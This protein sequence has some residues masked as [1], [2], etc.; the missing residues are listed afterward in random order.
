MCL[1]FGLSNVAVPEWF[2]AGA[3]G[4]VT[5][6]TLLLRNVPALQENLVSVF[7]H[8]FY[9]IIIFEQLFYK[10]SE[11]ICGSVL[12]ENYSMSNRCFESA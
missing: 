3:F 2:A 12:E 4:L 7:V 6:F 1:I 10:G 5:V 11:R 9:L 8:V